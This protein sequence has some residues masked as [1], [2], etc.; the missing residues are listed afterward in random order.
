MGRGVWPWRLG[1]TSYILPGDLLANARFLAPRVD[2]VELVL[3]ESE[4]FGSNIPEPE[5][6]AGLADLAAEHALTYTVH[7][8]THLR[9]GSTRAS[10]RIR[11]VDTWN[12]VMER[13]APLEPFGYVLHLEGDRPGPVPSLDIPAW[14]ENLDR[15]LEAWMEK[16]LIPARCVCVETLGYPFELVWPLVRRRGLAVTL[17]IGH[18]WAMGYDAEASVQ[19]LLSH[20]RIVHLHGVQGI[21]GEDHLGLEV[22]DPI[23]LES[24]L[25]A[26]SSQRG[27][28][29]LTLEVFCQEHLESSLEVLE[30]FRSQL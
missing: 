23:L 1:T 15:S 4:G 6:V 17:D 21:G 29:V 10:E 9:P 7:L 24:F 3:F 13:T 12:R 2:D 26:L 16:T 5:T 30:R 20:A 14:L 11:A 19:T 28:R 18:V 8:P 22:T 27:D 25:K